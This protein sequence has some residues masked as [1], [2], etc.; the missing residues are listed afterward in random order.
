MLLSKS[1]KSLDEDNNA[2][3]EAMLRLSEFGRSNNFDIIQKGGYIFLREEIVA[4]FPYLTLLELKNIIKAG[5]KGKIDQGKT[6]KPLNCTRIYQWVAQSVE[7]TLSHWQHRYPALLAWL[8][9]LGLV[10]AFKAELN[11]Y[12]TPGAAFAQTHKFQQL[13]Q[14]IVKGAFYPD[15]H[16]ERFVID[17]LA[18]YPEQAAAYHKI[19]HDE[20]E[21]YCRRYPTEIR[22]H[23]P[24]F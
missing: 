3:I 22:A 18:Q 13:V 23:Q 8:E 1:L 21:D 19:V 7:F 15:L 2:L 10:E 4:D 11:T 12:E 17:N 5:V 14:R 24:I 16:T 6:A 9:Q 20:Y